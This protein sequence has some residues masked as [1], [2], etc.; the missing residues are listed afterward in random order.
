ML[1][2]I[3]LNQKDKNMYSNEEKAKV[4]NSRVQI[5]STIQKMNNIKQCVGLDD[6][7]PDAIRQRK[8]RDNANS[9]MYRVDNNNVV[10]LARDIAERNWTVINQYSRDQAQ[11]VI[12]AFINSGYTIY[13]IPRRVV[14]TM[15]LLGHGEQVYAHGRG[16][17]DSGTQGD[18]MG[19]IQ[20]CVNELIEW[21]RNNPKPKKEKSTKKNHHNQG[22]GGDKGGKGGK[23]NDHSG[24]DGRIGTGHLASWITGIKAW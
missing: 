8:L 10:Q 6:N 22:G 15:D 13:E 3:K 9:T 4:N 19:R 16:G 11:R 17:S 2:L 21:A 12:T 24:G 7:R 18:T 1:Q 23:D 5:R 14:R 20:D